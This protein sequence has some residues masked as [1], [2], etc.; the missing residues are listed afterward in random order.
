MTSN[1]RKNAAAWNRL[2][3]NGSQFAKV[4]TDE[5]CQNPLQTLD[6]R[7]WLPASV[8]GLDVLCLAS[9]GGWQSILYASAGAGIKANKEMS[10]RFS[11]ETGNDLTTDAARRYFLDNIVGKDGFASA[12][13]GE[14]CRP[15]GNEHEQG[16]EADSRS[17]HVNPPSIW[18]DCRP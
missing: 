16:N 17:S 12:A 6:S 18:R 13:G 3:D 10:K 9:G 14:D 5:E 2:A 8:D 7:G 4:A 15:E 11:R 1:L